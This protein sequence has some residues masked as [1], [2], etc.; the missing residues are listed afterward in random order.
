[1]NYEI[2]KKRFD[3]VLSKVEKAVNGFNLDKRICYV[4]LD[5]DE[6]NDKIVCNVFWNRMDALRMYSNQMGEPNTQ[7]VELVKGMIG[8]IKVALSVHYDDC[9]RR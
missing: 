8:T 6:I 4:R 5:Y 2:N 3:D 1:M 9:N 7:I